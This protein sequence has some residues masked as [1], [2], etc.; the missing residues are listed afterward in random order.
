MRI[1]VYGG[2]FNPPHVGHGMVAAWLKWT[3]LVDEVWL[4]P[5]YDHPFGKALCPFELRVSWCE[6]LAGAVGPWVV[7]DRIESELTGASY[8]ID[9]LDLLTARHPEHVFRLVTGADVLPTVSKWKAWDRIRAEFQPIVVGRM[10]HGSGEVDVAFPEVS[11]TAI[12]EGLR[13]GTDV[14]A[15]LP[16]AVAALIGD[17]FTDPKMGP[18]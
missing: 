14:S 5:T 18:G 9:T 3:D 12:R 6:A 4:I 7:V 11:S 15:L 1:A 13:A 8:T 17:A 16:A 10:G 2:S